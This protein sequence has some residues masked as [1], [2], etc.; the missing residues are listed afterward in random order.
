MYLRL[1]LQWDLELL[2]ELRVYFILR[3]YRNCVERAY[4]FVNISELII[5]Q[6][7]LHADWGTA[8][9]FGKQVIVKQTLI[10]I[11]I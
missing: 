2:S 11:N 5:D 10:Q 8:L 1:N 3:F 7:V 4:Y 6:I 9:L